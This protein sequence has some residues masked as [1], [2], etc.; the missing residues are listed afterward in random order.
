MSAVLGVVT[1]V[2]VWGPDV[3]EAPSAN[4]KL[5][6]P[7]HLLAGN[8]RRRWELTRVVV[9]LVPG[10]VTVLVAVV[11]VFAVSMVAAV[12]FVAAA[13]GASFLVPPVRWWRRWAYWRARWWLDAR[14]ADLTL[15]AEPGLFGTDT[16][17]TDFEHV[18]VAP[19]LAHPRLTAS[20][21]RSVVKP[22]P[23]QVVADYEV[24]SARLAM[25]WVAADVSIEYRI[26]DRL[27][28]I[29]VAATVPPIENWEQS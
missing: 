23:G 24:A 2:S 10:I 21:R 19:V 28:A 25:R 17:A 27:V 12:L 20:G 5:A 26:G 13:M 29:V 15:N 4:T 6:G 9:V 18:V 11:L 1:V 7:R 3:S 22:L 14:S 8:L 16:G